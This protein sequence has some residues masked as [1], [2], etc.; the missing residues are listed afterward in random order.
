MANLREKTVSPGLQF[1]TPHVVSYHIHQWRVEANAFTV[2]FNSAR[3][4]G[5][6]QSPDAFEPAGAFFKCSKKQKSADSFRHPRSELF[7]T[8]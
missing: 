3:R 5:M 8:Y 4:L 7:R 1:K 6:R 2:A